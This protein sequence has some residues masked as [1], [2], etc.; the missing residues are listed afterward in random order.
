[1]KTRILCLLAA[2]LMALLGSPVYAMMDA[3]GMGDSSHSAH[4]AEVN[5]AQ[6][7]CPVTGEAVGK[8][9]KLTYEY[10][11]KV[12]KFCC[13]ACIDAFKKDP[14]KYT[15]AKAAGHEHVH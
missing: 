8:D 14:A 12:Y 6:E 4:A 11:G 2:A 9:T 10:D 3:C 13:P 1:M 5:A 7:V 15:S